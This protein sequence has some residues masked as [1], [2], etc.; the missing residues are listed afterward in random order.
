[1]TTELRP[2]AAPLEPPPG[3][4]YRAGARAALTSFVL[5]FFLVFVASVAVV[6]GV[7]GARSW[8]HPGRFWAEVTGFTF[9]VGGLVAGGVAS[10]GVL[11]AVAFG[12]AAL[13]ARRDRRAPR[14]GVAGA[15][16]ALPLTGRLG[17]G[18]SRATPL[19]VAA[20]IAGMVGL[21]FGA[22]ALV[23][24]AGVHD[25]GVMPTMASALHGAPALGVAGAL[26]GIVVAPGL[27]EDAF[28]RG[29]M[30]PRMVASWGLWPGIVATAIAF[31]LIHVDL[32]QGSLAAVAGVYLGWA[33]ERFG[34][35]RPTI[36]AHV[37]NNALFVALSAGGLG[38][39]DARG[40]R[41]WTAAI[42]AGGLVVL[43]GAIAVLRGPRAV[44]S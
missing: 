26:L 7:A 36:A 19:G 16:A 17:L 30:Q 35:I 29:W 4:S 22:S 14:L 5:A 32:V 9:S 44:R 20:A 18:A 33:A 39:L 13:E 38:D 31:G 40:S 3:A 42:A 24:L 2:S 15:T 12:A 6:W 10:G 37:V 1:V 28:F 41:A 21:S 8:G 23:A 25:A 27:A 11:G 43:A 34:G